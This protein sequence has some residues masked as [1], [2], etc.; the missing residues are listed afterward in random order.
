MEG[1]G[2]GEG[3]VGATDEGKIGA[4]EYFS[5][6]VQDADLILGK[7]MDAEFRRKGMIRVT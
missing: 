3:R 5:S 7:Y 1:A 2:R 4:V 6:A